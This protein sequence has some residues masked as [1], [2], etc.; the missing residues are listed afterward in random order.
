MPHIAVK[1]HEG[2]SIETK[3]IFAEA[4]KQ[5]AIDILG[6]NAC[7]VTVSIEDIAP[8][9]WYRK[10]YKPDIL[11]WEN[12]IIPPGYVEEPDKAN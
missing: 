2:R 6:C 8:G 10:V 11:E 7:Y 12:L 4:V 5:S 9:D 3:R 1:I